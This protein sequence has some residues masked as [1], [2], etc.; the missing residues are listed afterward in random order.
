[1]PSICNRVYQCIKHNVSM[2]SIDSYCCSTSK[3]DSSLRCTASS[4]ALIPITCC[5]T[6]HRAERTK[7][8]DFSQE[9]QPSENPSELCM[10][11]NGTWKWMKWHSCVL[12]HFHLTILSSLSFCLFLLCS[13]CLFVVFPIFFEHNFISFKESHQWKKDIQGHT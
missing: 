5:Y 10:A 9:L 1:M 11:Q 2:L 4:S 8:L 3:L 13:V 6:I 12:G 7:I